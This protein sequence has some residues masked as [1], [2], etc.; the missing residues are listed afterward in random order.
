MTRAILLAA[1]AALATPAQADTLIDNV[2]GQTIGA[3]GHVERFK[4]M[5]MDDA[6]VV[7]ALIHEGEKIPKKGFQYRIDGKGRIAAYVLN[8][9]PQWRPEWGGLLLFPGS[10]GAQAEAFVPGFNR[11][12]LLRVPQQHCVTE[13]SRAA[14][15]RRYAITGW[16]RR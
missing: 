5:L 11:L 15:F 16:L 10:D 3:D 14:A 8:L 4:A 2:A 6:G 9:T 12:S 7:K 1:A 13:V